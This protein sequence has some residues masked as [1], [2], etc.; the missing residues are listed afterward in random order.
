MRMRPPATPALLS[1]A[2]RLSGPGGLSA[3]LLVL[4]APLLSAAPLV[5][6]APLGAQLR[7]DPEALKMARAML[8]KRATAAET[9]ERV[10]AERRL[11]AAH[12]PAVLAAAG[13]EAR[14]IG[15][16][17]ETVFRMGA[18][19][20][21]RT[22]MKALGDATMA[23]HAIWAMRE[24]HDE[25]MKI[26]R[27][28]L[29]LDA[30]T[31]LRARVDALEETAAKAASE[32]ESY[33]EL[34][35][36]GYSPAEA[37]E[38]MVGVYRTTAE[39]MVELM[40][41]AG[42]T[43]GEILQVLDD[44]YG[45]QREQ[46]IELMALSGVTPEEG[47]AALNAAGAKASARVYWAFREAIEGGEQSMAWL[48]DRSQILSVYTSDVMG[49]LA[50]MRERN[51]DPAAM[52]IWAALSEAVVWTGSL[53]DVPVE[54]MSAIFAV[55]V[56]AGVDPDRIGRTMHRLG[57]RTTAILVAMARV[58]DRVASA[59]RFGIEELGLTSNEAVRQVGT[60]LQVS[61]AFLKDAVEVGATGEA[62]AE[63]AMELRNQGR[64]A[65]Q[66][67]LAVG[68]A[69]G[70]MEVARLLIDAGYDPLSVQEALV[71]G[72]GMVMAEAVE[73]LAQ[74]GGG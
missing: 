35:G 73:L 40:R 20:S 55:L 37:T 70:F 57:A 19:E 34:R 66:L 60:G 59:L 68:E 53:A 5:W 63:I 16:V 13:V 74:L 50:A 9:A 67:A 22:S 69:L 65:V 49:V 4:L 46:M 25:A 8:E 61:I 17:H 3:I 2:A 32:R 18:G 30:R 31:A 28:E 47:L 23:F 45:W 36:A 6:A 71:E 11:D 33:R 43:W 39:K 56:E 14:E 12:V 24:S 72:L 64:S 51:L 44:A 62:L 21:A 48:A 54:K 41:A 38:A 42:A 58:G 27:S 26:A 15:V 10:R 29:R 1:G 52:V 7:P